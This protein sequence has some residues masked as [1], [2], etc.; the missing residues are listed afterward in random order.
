[1]EKNISIIGILLACVLLVGGLYVMTRPSEKP[2]TLTTEQSDKLSVQ[3]N[4]HVFG[5]KDGKVTLVEY[6]DFECPPC[7]A[8]YPI[9]KE[10]EKKHPEVRFVLRYFPLSGHLNAMNAAL[11]AEA[12]A[13]Q[14]K[15]TEMHA[16][17]F[18]HQD[19]WG[20]KDAADP[21]LFVTYAQEIGLDVEQ[22]EKDRVSDA[23]KARVQES[24]DTG[25]AVGVRGTPTFFLNGKLLDTPR[26]LEDFSAVLTAAEA[27]DATPQQ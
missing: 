9:V 23:V 12:A 21:A 22:W 26:S 27:Q 16:E 17:I 11:A 24:F 8:Y 15:F 20:G 13:V 18:E 10:L 14:G 4:D 2:T 25:V 7:G 1:M 6:Y 3:A 19:E 5:A